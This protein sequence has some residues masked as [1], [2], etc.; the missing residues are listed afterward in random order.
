MRGSDFD[1]FMTLRFNSLPM[2]HSS[3]LVPIGSIFC[4]VA[5]SLKSNN[6]FEGASPLGKTLSLSYS[7]LNSYFSGSCGKT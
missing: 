5:T 4:F 1:N 6:S 7:T 2:L 3:M